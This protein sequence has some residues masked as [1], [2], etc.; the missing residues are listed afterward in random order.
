MKYLFVVC[1]AAIAF[2]SGGLFWNRFLDPLPACFTG[3]RIVDGDT[4]ECEWRRLRLAGFDTPESRPQDAS[5][6]KEVQLG[7][8][9][10]C[11][12]QQ[13]VAPGKWQVKKLKKSGGHERPLVT[14]LIGGHD[15]KAA[16]IEQK[17]ARP[18]D[19]KG[20]KPNWCAIIDE[21]PE[22]LNIDCLPQ[23]K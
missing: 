5:C 22:L 9:A 8:I 16:M 14:L 1:V 23:T 18:Y 19:A 20:V 17:L 4:I 21:N 3:L 2:V 12:L 10:T 6:D 13:H 7:K 15:I 11:A